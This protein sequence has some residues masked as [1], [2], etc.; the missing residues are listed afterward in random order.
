MK[1]YQYKMQWL[2]SL[3]GD[4]TQSTVQARKKVSDFINTVGSQSFTVIYF[5]D[6]DLKIVD[7]YNNMNRYP[8][9]E[10]ANTAL[11]GLIGSIKPEG[12]IKYIEFIRK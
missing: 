3:N 1:T 12:D 6:N 10:Q 8:D 9:N 11:I 4:F 7:S 2:L 5:R